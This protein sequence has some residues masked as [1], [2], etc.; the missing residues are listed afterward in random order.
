LE[1][2]Y[3]ESRIL[4]V[5]KLLGTEA[6]PESQRRTLRTAKKIREEFLQQNANDPQDTFTPP[7]KQAEMMAE[8]VRLA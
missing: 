6:L 7:E 3:E 4:E 8:I 1:I 5:V 2:L